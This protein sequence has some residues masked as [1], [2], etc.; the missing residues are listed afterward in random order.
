MGQ[1]NIRLKA[2][3]QAHETEAAEAVAQ[4]GAAE[5]AVKRLQAELERLRT[6]S[7]DSLV[8]GCW[9]VGS[10]VISTAFML[11]HVTLAWCGMLEVAFE[12]CKCRGP[13][14]QICWPKSL[15]WSI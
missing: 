5:K 14:S 10:G 3:L 6:A 13:C 8:T 1:E 15:H 12:Y 4:L 9:H 7:G 11:N 2:Q